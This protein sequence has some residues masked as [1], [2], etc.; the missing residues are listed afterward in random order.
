MHPN[1]QHVIPTSTMSPEF[2][3]FRFSPSLCV[4]FTSNHYSCSIPILHFLSSLYKPVQPTS[5]RSVTVIRSVLCRCHS[6]CLSL[7][8]PFSSTKVAP[9]PIGS[10]LQTSRVARL[11]YL[12]SGIL[13]YIVSTC[14]VTWSLFVC[15]FCFVSVGGLGSYEG[16]C[17]FLCF[18]SFFWLA[19][20]TWPLWQNKDSKVYSL[21]ALVSFLHPVSAP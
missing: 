18:V 20:L 8:M 10:A 17:W 4:C 5:S 15:L 21:P 16:A 13:S 19:S 6:S 12:C 14:V 3:I 2:Q 7:L 11:I 1:L 9:L